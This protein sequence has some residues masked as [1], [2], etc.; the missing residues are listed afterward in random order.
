MSRK[1]KVLHG[2]A[3]NMLRV[4]LSMLVSL[5]LPPFLVHRLSTAEYSA[6]VLI[7]QLSG[8]VSMLDLGLQT[9]VGKFIAE[10][11]A[12]DDRATSTRVLSTSFT[13][14]SLTA[15][16]GAVII[17][18]MTWCVPQ[19]FHQMP[20]ALVRSVREGLL[21][22]GLSVA[23]ALPFGVFAAAF[24]GL[25]EYSFPTVLATVS[26]IL[27]AATVVGLV[28]MHGSLVQLALVMAGF[29]VAAAAMQF[30]GWRKYLRKR[31]D[32][33]LAA[34]DRKTA[35]R[36]I[37]YGS[38][39]SLWSVAALLV[40]GLDILIVG[41][42]DYKNTGF[43]A[44]ASSATNF[45]LTIIGSIFNPVLP[46]VSSLQASSTPRQIGD[47]LI[48]VT[49]YC[50]VLLCLFGSTLLFAAYPLL[51]LWVGHDYAVQ[52]VLY[53]EILVLGNVLKQL[54]YPYAL[55]VVATGKQHLATIAA[56]TEAVVNVVV[57]VLLVR[58]IGAVGVA[59]GTLVGA[60]FSLGMHLAVSM[61]YTQSTISIR[62][63][64]FALQGLLRPLLSLAPSLLL[65]PFWRRFNMLPANPALLALWGALTLAIA[66]RIGLTLEDRREVIN[67][68]SRLVYWRV[69]QT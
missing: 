11:S 26:R 64:R 35:A 9:A 28:L 42:Y 27:S 55:V 61:H 19:L 12:L 23:F 62:R 8:Y 69:Q 21:A 39:L 68:V 2:S 1:R 5:V 57:S 48:R 66:W 44:V 14:L 51:S 45:M 54:T 36:L 52:S 25:Q 58:R 34:F 46:A 6:W 59:I 30:I 22:V 17:A 32:F 56:I 7:L 37:K 4:L 40:S 29:N 65:Y 15:L 38:V 20:L 31:V 16:L 13:I 53:L 60:F 3:S 18:I 24:T 41:H 49:R 47:L 10:H 33:S 50:T 43:Y 67:T 63:S